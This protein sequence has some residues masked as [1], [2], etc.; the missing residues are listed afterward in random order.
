MA[1]CFS[2]ILD[3]TLDVSHVEKML[4]VV[5]FDDT[6]VT[7]RKAEENVMIREFIRFVPLEE[8]IGGNTLA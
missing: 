3:C 6:R 2:I 4:A 5:R 7:T 1:R 8:I